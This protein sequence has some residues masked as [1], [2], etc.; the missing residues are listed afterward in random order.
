L[1]GQHVM[2]MKMGPICLPFTSSN[3]AAA[4]KKI[5]TRYPKFKINW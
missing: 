5:V 3:L 1:Q 2:T 4:F